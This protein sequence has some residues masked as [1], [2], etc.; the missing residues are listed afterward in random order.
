MVAV[1]GFGGLPGLLPKQGICVCSVVL[2]VFWSPQNPKEIT[3]ANPESKECM[4][5]K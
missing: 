4:K 2:L 1:P 5:F 3:A